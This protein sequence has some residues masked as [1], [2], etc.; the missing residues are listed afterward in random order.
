M[1][2]QPTNNRNSV[3]SIIIGS[4]LG[5]RLRCRYQNSGGGYSVASYI[6]SSLRFLPP[7]RGPKGVAKTIEGRFSKHAI[8]ISF[9]NVT[10]LKPYPEYTLISSSHTFLRLAESV[11]MPPILIL[12]T[13][14]GR[15]ATFRWQL[16]R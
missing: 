14:S 1:M 5:H 13:N 4:P 2:R 15:Y 16:Y 12:V 7:R 8:F 10:G 6:L 3:A 11:L 9:V